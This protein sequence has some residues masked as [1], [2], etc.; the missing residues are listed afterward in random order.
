V[1]W[2]FVDVGHELAVVIRML[3]LAIVQVLGWL[4]LPARGRRGEDCGVAR[5]AT[6]G[7]SLA[8]RLGGGSS[9]RRVDQPAEN[10]R[11]ESAPEATTLTLA[12]TAFVM[13]VT[14]DRRKTRRRPGP[15]PQFTKR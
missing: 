8:V 10:G 3:Y 13:P 14:A 5:S 7:S 11:A 12:I 2:W 6:R 15:D 9:F 1:S 4:A